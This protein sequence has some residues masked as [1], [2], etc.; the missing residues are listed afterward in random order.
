MKELYIAIL[1][2]LSIALCASCQSTPKQNQE[3]SLEVSDSTVGTIETT[4]DQSG[5]KA[6]EIDEVITNNNAGERWWV[7]LLVGF[8]IPMPRVIKW[9]F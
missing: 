5:V 1:L 2:V 4:Q 7:W 3:S 6:K 8:L 9:F